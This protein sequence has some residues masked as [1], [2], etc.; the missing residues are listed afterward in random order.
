[1][2]VCI[3]MVRKTI[4]LT[5]N[6]SMKMICVVMKMKLIL[7]SFNYQEQIVQ[8]TEVVEYTDFTSAEGYDPPLSVMDMTLNDL[9]VRFQ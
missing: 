6:F 4:H 1:M 9:M 8:S 3:R 5:I 2:S 7:S